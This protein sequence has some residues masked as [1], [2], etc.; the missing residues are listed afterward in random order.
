MD[1]AGVVARQPT[2]THHRV[3]M[4]AHQAGGFADAAAFRNVLQDRADFL[5]R[6]GRAEQRRPF[7]L[8]ESRLAGPAAEHPPL[9]VRSIA[10]TYRQIFTSAF[11]VVGTLRILTTK[12]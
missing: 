1:L 7:T 5:L 11:P 12:P 3:P 8:G 6:Q 10:I 4:D 2:V 9:L